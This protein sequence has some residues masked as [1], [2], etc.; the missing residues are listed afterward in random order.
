[1]STFSF[2]KLG[3]LNTGLTFTTENMVIT[4]GTFYTASQESVSAF[5][6]NHTF[7]QSS[8]ARCPFLTSRSVHWPSGGLMRTVGEK[9]VKTTFTLHTRKKS[10][11]NI[12]EKFFGK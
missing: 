1:M 6:V 9:I 8:F 3:Y 7:Q 2:K 10:G 5:S 4:Q 11:F 12:F